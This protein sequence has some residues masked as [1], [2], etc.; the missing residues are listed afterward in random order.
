[1]STVLSRLNLQS[2]EIWCWENCIKATFAW[3]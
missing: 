2:V 3:N 1:M